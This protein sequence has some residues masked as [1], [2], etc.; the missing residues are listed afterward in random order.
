MHRNNIR[1]VWDKGQCAVKGLLAIPAA[2]SAEVMVHC[3]WMH[4]YP[5]RPRQLPNCDHHDAGDLDDAGRTTVR[6]PWND[7]AIIMK[8]LKCHEVAT[9]CRVV[10]IGLSS[11]YKRL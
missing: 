8:R 4:R 1:E 11:H 6:L 9:V 3:G 10:S 5:A 7:P 2:F